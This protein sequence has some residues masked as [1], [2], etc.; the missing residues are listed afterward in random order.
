MCPQ[1]RPP[2]SH[3]TTCPSAEMY[4]SN[5][6]SIMEGEELNDAWLG[7]YPFD[8]DNWKAE[9]IANGKVRHYGGQRAGAWRAALAGAPSAREDAVL[10]H[11]RGGP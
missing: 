6:Y 1:A 10:I 9:C 5:T 11:T 2:A 7:N 8:L 3:C 4:C